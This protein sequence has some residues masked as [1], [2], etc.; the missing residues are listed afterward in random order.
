MGSSSPI[1]I[2]IKNNNQTKI[3]EKTSDRLYN[4]I[5][6]IYDVD[7]K[8]LGTGFFLKLNIVNTVFYFLVTSSEVITSEH[9]DN[10]GIINLYYGKLENETHLE[11][12]IEDRT[13]FIFYQPIKFTFIGIE[14]YD[15]IPKENFLNIDMNYKHG[16]DIYKEKNLISAGYQQNGKEFEKFISV[17]EISNITN[18]EFEHDMEAG[19][20]SKGSPICLHDSLL[21]IG[22]HQKKDENV[23]KGNFIGIAFNALE[24]KRRKVIKQTNSYVNTYK[25]DVKEYLRNGKGIAYYS[26]GSS[27]D[28]DWVNDM[29]EGRGIMIY[30]NGNK[31]EGDWKN[32]IREGKG[33][34]YFSNGD[35]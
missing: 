6:R 27:Y 1:Q 23:S 20:G 2:T 3:S 14:E 10:N 26:D 16:Y 25:G 4:S 31:Y 30:A 8:Y 34:F 19:I 18:V 12:E 17:G 35:T 24:D 21:V 33:I 9:L 13:Q 15:N 7:N 32:D 5:S 29:R 22:I 28:G 11:I